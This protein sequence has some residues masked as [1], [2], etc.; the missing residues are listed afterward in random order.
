MV[1]LINWL[2]ITLGSTVL[3]HILLSNVCTSPLRRNN[4]NENM[5]GDF[6]K[7]HRPD[8][9][10]H[11]VEGNTSGVRAAR[12][13]RQ[14]Q[15]EQEEFERR[16]R[17]WTVDT[18]SRTGRQ[19]QDRGLG[20][21]RTIRESHTGKGSRYPTISKFCLDLHDDLQSTRRPSGN[22]SSAVLCS[23]L[24]HRDLPHCI[25]RNIFGILQFTADA[26][27]KKRAKANG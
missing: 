6:H 17:Q 18:S 19:G 21:G 23:Y 10:S 20:I 2:R 8:A 5:T 27:K 7:F 25:M 24:F 9:G 22:C 4:K 11:T 14:R 1:V 3:T 15:L 12:L 26:R 16:K 13:E